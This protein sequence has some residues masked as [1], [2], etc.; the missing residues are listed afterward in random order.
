MEPTLD[1]LLRAKR[2]VESMIDS[3][4]Y[5]LERYEQMIF[6]DEDKED[7]KHYSGLVF[8]VGQ[9]G[10]N[11]KS[12]K[13]PEFVYAEYEH[14][15]WSSLANMRNKLYHGYEHLDLDVLYDTIENHLPRDLVFFEQVEEDLSRR[16][17]ALDL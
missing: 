8:E 9:I 3:I 15:A 7:R 16:I 5:V 14:P 10:E 12:D 1:E 17:N 13:M 11:L 4:H 2:F 6:Y